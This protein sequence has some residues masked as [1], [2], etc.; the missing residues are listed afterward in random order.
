MKEVIPKFSLKEVLEAAAAE[1]VNHEL[2]MYTV[3]AEVALAVAAEK[4]NHELSLKTVEDA[5]AKKVKEKGAVKVMK[6]DM[7]DGVG[8]TL[9]KN[10][11]E[12]SVRRITRSRCPRSRRSR[13]RG[14]G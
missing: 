14:S 12:G 4:A 7:V 6:G 3:L 2:S 11:D 13:R 10:V 9:A 8:E 5:Q 1:K